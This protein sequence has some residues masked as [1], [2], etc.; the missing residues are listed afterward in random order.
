MAMYS[1]GTYFRVPACILCLI[2]KQAESSGTAGVLVWELLPSLAL[3]FCTCTACALSLPFVTAAA[4]AAATTNSFERRPPI[5]GNS[6]NDVLRRQW[7][8]GAI[9]PMTTTCS[10]RHN[11]SSPLTVFLKLHSLSSARLGFLGTEG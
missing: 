10:Q 11:A 2:C 1:R 6:Y 4:A 3:S 8:G 9:G 5:S 7:G